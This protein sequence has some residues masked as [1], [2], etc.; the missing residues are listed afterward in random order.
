MSTHGAVPADRDLEL[1]SFR[2]WNQ[3]SSLTDGTM[4]VFASTDYNIGG[5]YSTTT[6][7]WT[8]QLPGIYLFTWALHSADTAFVADTSW[9]LETLQRSGN[10]E[11][12]AFPGLWKTAS[13]GQASHGDALVRV[14]QAD[15]TAGHYFAI[16][17]ACSDGATARTY[18]T[19]DSN[20]SFFSG[21]CLI[22][23][24]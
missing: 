14:T 12:P 20:R 16:R 11:F 17:H 24:A 15:I 3:P 7:R 1:G 6:G 13:Y 8:P 10:D 9:W 2:A 21:A 4:L 18:T 5:W 23:Y 19:N 22:P